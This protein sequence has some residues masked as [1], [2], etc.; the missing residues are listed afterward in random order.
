[1]GHGYLASV[2]LPDGAELEIRRL[3]DGNNDH[4]TSDRKPKS[5]RSIGQRRLVIADCLYR[6]LCIATGVYESV[7]DSMI[8]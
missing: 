5:P 3:L 7:G 6:Y 2:R 1:M 4:F 8:F